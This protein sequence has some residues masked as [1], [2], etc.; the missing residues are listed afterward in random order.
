MKRKRISNP[1]LT[2]RRHFSIF[3]CPLPSD[4]SVDRIFRTIGLGHYSLKRGFQQSVVDLVEELVPLTRHLWMSTK[5]PTVLLPPTFSLPKQCERRIET[6]RSVQA[7]MLPTPARF[8]YIFNLRELSRIW[9]GM[10]STLATVVDSPQVDPPFSISSSTTKKKDWIVPRVVT[11]L[12]SF[13]LL[14][15][16][17]LGILLYL[18][19]VSLGLIEVLSRFI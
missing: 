12:P 2:C 10:T 13:H 11:W 19:R 16:C 4:T 8:H 17:R 14:L 7:K 9:Q 1:L 3:N 6:R 15:S 18:Y 5:V